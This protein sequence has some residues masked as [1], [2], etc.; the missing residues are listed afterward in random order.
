MNLRVS[1]KGYVMTT[2]GSEE[3]L[4]YHYIPTVTNLLEVLWLKN[5]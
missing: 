3:T 5:E 2:L 4:V 1:Q